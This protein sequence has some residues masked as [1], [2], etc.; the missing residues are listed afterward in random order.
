MGSISVKTNKLY[1]LIN[2]TRLA[3]D[4]ANPGRDEDVFVRAVFV[5]FI[6]EIL[7]KKKQLTAATNQFLCSTEM[8]E[9]HPED[10]HVYW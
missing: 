2:L 3:V 6:R 10:F 5:W 1:C 8:H 7:Q 4:L 9:V